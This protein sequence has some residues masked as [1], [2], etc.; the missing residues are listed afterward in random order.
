MT[1]YTELVKSLRVCG[2]SLEAAAF[3]EWDVCLYTQAADA[4]EELDNEIQNKDGAETALRVAEEAKPRW[5]SVAERLPRYG[6]WVLGIGKKKG[7]YVCEFRGSHGLP[8]F[9]A[10][11]RTLNITHWQ[12]LPAPQREE[13]E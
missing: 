4:I 10:N 6:D 1:D 7:Y 5:V 8:W 2:K 9:S 3:P 13:T 12:P 11:G